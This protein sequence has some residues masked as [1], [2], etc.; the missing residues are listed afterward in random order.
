MPK[1]HLRG[2]NSRRRFAG[3]FAAVLVRGVSLP[4]WRAIRER[5]CAFRHRCQ[6]R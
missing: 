2:G 1:K 4:S 5:W 3:N 6:G